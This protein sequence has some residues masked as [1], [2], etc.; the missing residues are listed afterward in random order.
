MAPV[1]V[2]E[3]ANCGSNATK[4]CAGCIGA[5]EYE[6]E[7]SIS[8]AY[9]SR[10]CQRELWPSHRHRCRALQQRKKLL[11]AANLLKAALL[12]YKEVVYDVD[13]KK[14]ELKNGVLCLYQNESRDRPQPWPASFP[15][16]LTP[17]IEHKEAA[18][19]VNQ[20]TTAMALLGC[21]TRKLLQ[22]EQSLIMASG[23]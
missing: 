9:Y 2:T 6:P 12:T 15:S 4:R 17:D 21:M 19:A 5:L 3:C 10:E 22:G 8:T 14:V 20:C 7:D 18:L 16:H 1:S 23:W 11:R 13:L